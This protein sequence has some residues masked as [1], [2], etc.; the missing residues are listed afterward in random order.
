MVDL[1]VLLAVLRDLSWLF[2]V[3]GGSLTVFLSEIQGPQCLGCEVI[4]FSLGS[5]EDLR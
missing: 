4:G 1:N 5:L 3:G 2:D